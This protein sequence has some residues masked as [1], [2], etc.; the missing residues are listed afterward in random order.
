MPV[1]PLVGYPSGVRVGRALPAA[2]YPYV[3]V[4]VPTVIARNPNITLAGGRRP[5]FDYGR[6]GSDLDHDIG[7]EGAGG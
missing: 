7:T 1:D 5:C 6:R 4:A 3:S 2:A